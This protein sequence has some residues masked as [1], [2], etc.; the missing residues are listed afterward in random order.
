MKQNK[1][2]YT[3]IYNWF[4]YYLV[5]PDF[6]PTQERGAERGRE[7]G[8]KADSITYS[9]AIS[10]YENAGTWVHALQLFDGMESSRVEANT[11]TYS[12][13]ISVCEKAGEWVR[14]LQLLQSMENSRVEANTITYSAAIRVCE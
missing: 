2:I 7:R 12:A 14:A 6:S 5:L 1:T 11:I 10:A 8:G 13:A 3:S 9:A 4:L